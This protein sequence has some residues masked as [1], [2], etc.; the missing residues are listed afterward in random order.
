MSS[1]SLPKLSKSVLLSEFEYTGK[2][3]MLR[4]EELNSKQYVSM[5]SVKAREQSILKKIKNARML[6]L[7]KD[8]ILDELI[9]DL[10]RGE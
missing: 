3:W 4:D 8:C 2:G 6:E 9:E 5:E 7:Y 1:E 10:E